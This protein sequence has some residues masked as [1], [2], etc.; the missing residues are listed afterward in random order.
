MAQTTL[1]KALII[2]P[3]QC[4][5][6]PITLRKDCVSDL[7]AL[8][9]CEMLEVVNLGMV[10]HDIQHVAWID[11][12]GLLR[13]PFVYPKWALTN[14]HDGHGMAGYGVITGMDAYGAMANC[15]LNIANIV[16]LLG[17]EHWRSR[18][19]IDDVIP[20]MLRVYKVD[21]PGQR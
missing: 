15:F 2:D 8:L 13:Q 12:E 17:F 6:Y 1:L 16:H 20:Q 4:E 9:D 3:F 14:V 5:I 21:F 19:S 11:E 7:A 18:I 10:S